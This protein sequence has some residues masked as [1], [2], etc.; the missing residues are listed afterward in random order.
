MIIILCKEDYNQ[1]SNN[2]EDKAVVAKKE[3]K[4]VALEKGKSIYWCAC[5]RSLNQPYCDGSHKSTSITPK[6]LTAEKDETVFL[7]Q[8]KQTNNPPFCDGS[9]KKL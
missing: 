2:N 4:E 7:C 8:C 9:H 1:M 3:P 5:G 6:K